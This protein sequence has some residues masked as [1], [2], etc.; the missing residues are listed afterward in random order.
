MRRVGESGL[1]VMGY[2]GSGGDLFGLAGAVFDA[3]SMQETGPISGVWRARFIAAAAVI[4]LTGCIDSGGGS[5]K[6]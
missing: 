5:G 4:A 1:V 6:P 3:K 2:G